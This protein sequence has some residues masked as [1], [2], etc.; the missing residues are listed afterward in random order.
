MKQYHNNEKATKEA[1]VEGGWLRTGDIGHYDD[2]DHFFVTD[3]VKELIKVKGFQVAPAELEEIIRDHPAVE[4]AAVVGVPHAK[5]GQVPK[6]FVVV[7]SGSVL[8]NEEIQEY[9]SSRVTSYKRL[10]GGVAIIDK[11]PKSA[12]G[13]ILRKQ[14]ENN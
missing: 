4:D 11:I 13:K 1:F 7:K 9:V 10:T 2:D 3:R 5:F 12:S 8:K 6:G 14:L